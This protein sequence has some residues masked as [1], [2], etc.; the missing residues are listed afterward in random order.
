M[1][2]TTRRAKRWP[3]SGSTSISS[4]T[5]YGSERTGGWSSSTIGECRWVRR[6]HRTGGR[7]RGAEVAAREAVRLPAAALRGERRGLHG[8]RCRAQGNRVNGL[9]SV[10]REILLTDAAAQPFY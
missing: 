7:R 9:Q 10:F 3:R 6:A 4:T 5:A 8:L 2:F 1:V